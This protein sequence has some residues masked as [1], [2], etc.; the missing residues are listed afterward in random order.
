MKIKVQYPN[1]DD[2]REICRRQTTDY[3]HDIEHVVDVQTLIQ[4]QSIV[5]KV[6][7]AD[8][9]YEAAIDLARLSRPEGR[10]ASARIT[11]QD[12]VRSR[13]PGQYR[14]AH[15]RQGAGAAATALPC[16]NG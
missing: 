10:Q 15:G 11:G 9:V 7:V 2:E 5:P 3:S 1:R 13:P 12:S 14:F 16:N 4:M 8:H 6:I